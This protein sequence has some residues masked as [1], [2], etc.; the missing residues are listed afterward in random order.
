M[1]LTRI[2]ISLSVLREGRRED[3]SGEFTA[4]SGARKVPPGALHVVKNTGSINVALRFFI[5]LDRVEQAIK[6][7]ERE[8]SSRIDLPYSSTQFSFFQPSICSLSKWKR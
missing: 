8:N 6:E 4:G 7:R 3:S 5:N 2:Y 1:N